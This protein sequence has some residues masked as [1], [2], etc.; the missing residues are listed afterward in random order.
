MDR[1]AHT[2]T[3]PAAPTAAHAAPDGFAGAAG[4]LAAVRG[5][6][7][8]IE[9]TQREAIGAAATAV[10]AS[11]ADGGVMQ[12]FGTG[13]S[14]AFAMELC[15]RAGG[16]VP[17]NKLA[18]RDVIAY[19]G[20]AP[21]TLADPRAERDPAL[22]TRVFRLAAIEPKD[23]FV[24]ASQSGGNGSVV[25]MALLAAR[26]GHTV[27]AVTSLAH[28]AAITSRHACGKRLYEVADI[29]IDNGAP[30]GDAPLRLPGGDDL[31]AVSSIANAV[32]AQLLTAE[33]A[34]RL[35]AA[36]ERPPVYQS[37]NVEGG[38]AHNDALEA[39]YAGRVRRSAF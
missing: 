5:I 32:I 17:T 6:V 23:V 26:E 37:A 13:H 35:L 10:A 29:V 18:L 19:G 38:D 12:V 24:I 36:G 31:C 2:D 25:E 34:G 8:H 14:E 1:A 7:A 3:P 28:S 21:E 9:D 15:G 33:I 39:R 20:E 27:V 16:L 22:A 30:H 11:L 4:V